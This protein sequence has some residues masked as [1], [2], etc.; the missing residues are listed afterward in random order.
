MNL[1]LKLLLVWTD[2]K[3]FWITSVNLL[4]AGMYVMYRDG[5][6]CDFIVHIDPL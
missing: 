3:T 6:L 1:F 4:S 2:L 5:G